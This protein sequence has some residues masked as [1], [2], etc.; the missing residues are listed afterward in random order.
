[1]NIKRRHEDCNSPDVC[2]TGFIICWNESLFCLKRKGCIT[3]LR[4]PVTGEFIVLN[5]AFLTLTSGGAT[6]VC[7]F[8][9]NKHDMAIG[10]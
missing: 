7:S 3:R 2:V 1:V 5:I 4:I 8:S 9:A 6:T 10:W